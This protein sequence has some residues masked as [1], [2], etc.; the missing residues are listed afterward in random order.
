MPLLALNPF[1][2]FQ[3]LP[4]NPL[5]WPSFVEVFVEENLL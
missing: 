5:N 4:A 1:C 2:T 3:P